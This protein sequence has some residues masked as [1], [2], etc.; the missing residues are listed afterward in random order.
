MDAERPSN[1][2]E[3]NAV[4]KRQ[5]SHEQQRLQQE[6]DRKA[7][8]AALPAKPSNWDR[9]SAMEKRTWM[10]QAQAGARSQP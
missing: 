5:W 1:W 7:S 2:N 6:A 10:L 9:Y 8:L 4:D 3:M